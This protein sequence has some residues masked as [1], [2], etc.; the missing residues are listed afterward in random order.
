[1]FF[2]RKYCL[3]LLCFL[4]WS[5]EPGWKAL[6]PVIGWEALTLVPLVTKDSVPSNDFLSKWDRVPEVASSKGTPS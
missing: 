3:G 1:V 4:W 2:N 6:G 5:Q